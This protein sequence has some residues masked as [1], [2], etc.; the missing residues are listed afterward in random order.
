MVWVVFAGRLCVITLTLDIQQ[1]SPETE[2]N[3][4]L[5][6]HCFKLFCFFLEFNTQE[7]VK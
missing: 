1:V 7:A 5:F 4:V 2:K 6:T 3:I